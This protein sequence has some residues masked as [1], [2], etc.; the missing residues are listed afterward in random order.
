MADSKNR[1]NGVLLVDKPRG[2]TSHDVVDHLRRIIG[3]RRV[4]HTG[5]L[6][7]LAEGLL[8]TCLGR[9]TKLAQF[10]SSF[11]KTYDAEVYLGQSS[12]TFDG[13]GVAAA[14]PPK[15]VP[16]VSDDQLESLLCRFVG[17][18]TQRIPAHSAV[19]VGGQRLYKLARMGREV[20]LPER[21]VE[22]IDLQLLEYREPVLRIRVSCSPGTY[23]RALANDLGER[24]GCGAYLLGLRRTRVGQLSVDNALSLPEIERLCEHNELKERLLSPG[25]VL[26]YPAIV[27]SDDLRQAVL[28][29]R[30]ITSR[31]IIRLTGAFTEGQLVSVTDSDGNVLA[32]G[33][34]DAS[35]A[36]VSDAAS[37]SLFTYTRVLN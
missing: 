15:P 4:G 9:A 28:A 34:A 16:S 1:H 23:I 21:Q 30:S 24:L 17:T 19:K 36:L 33:T 12:V 7:P 26:P 5:T 29:G 20:E 27:V 13:E 35:S 3:Q 25:Q 14:G 10:I 11:D 18:I 31:Q 8:V 32:I 37:G 22:I 6:D 2:M